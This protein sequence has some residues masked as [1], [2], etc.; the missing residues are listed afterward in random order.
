M[1]L[2]LISMMVPP[3]ILAQVE[4]VTVIETPEAI[5]VRR[6]DN[7]VLTYHKAELEPPAEADSVYRRSGFIHPLCAPNGASVTGIHPK[8]HYHHL[9]LW[10]AWVRTKH[11]EDEPDFWNLG[12]GT[13]RVRYA[14]TVET[15]SAS[16]EVPS[17]GFT[18]LQEHVAY[19]GVERKETVI[20]EEVF[21]VSVTFE[22][23]ENVVRYEV[24][25]KNVSKEPLLLPVYRYGGGIAYRGPGNWDK[26]NSDYLTSEGLD[27]SNSHQSRARWV[28]MFGPTAK[29]EA[30]LTVMIHPDNHDF[31]QRLRTWPASSSNGA[32]F[33]NV[34][35]AQE[36]PWVIA[37]GKQIKMT[38]QLN[39]SNGKPDRGKIEDSWK[40]FSAR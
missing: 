40:R 8:D 20:L 21:E 28:A 24:T 12:A 15:R 30:T 1:K 7:P 36:S 3:M 32:M 18:V 31:P 26:T 13:G 17:A 35:P 9:G 5:E 39:V 27:R 38:Y 14:S 10:H 19:K 6:G 33:F 25:Q 23:G 22:D 29:G 16:K 11:G 2:L 4:E 37:P 34:V